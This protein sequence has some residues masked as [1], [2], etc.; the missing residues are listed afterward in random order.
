MRGTL[1]ICLLLGFIT[2]SLPAQEIDPQKVSR[3]IETA[4]K[5]LKKQQKPD[6]SW[7]DWHTFT[8]G[9]TSLVTLSLLE[10]GVPP[11]DEVIQKALNSLRQAPRESTYCVALQTMALC[12]AKYKTDIGLIQKNVDWLVDA[13]HDDGAWG[14]YGAGGRRGQ[15][16]SGTD[17]SNAQYA[18]LALYAAEEFS[19]NIEVSDRVWRMAKKYWAN[20]QNNDGSWGYKPKSRATG[21]MSC[22]GISSLYIA[23]TKVAEI[24]ALQEGQLCCQPPVESDALER[25]LRWMGQNFR[26]D[27]NPAGGGAWYYY[28]MYGLE[29]AGRLTASRFLVSQNGA[30][31]DWYREGVFELTHTNR[32]FL[33]GVFL[34]NGAESNK[35]ISTALALLFLAKGRRPLLMGKVKHGP[36]DDWNNHPQDAAHLAKHVGDEWGTPLSWQTIDVRAASVDELA[37][38][39]IL[40]ISGRDA[41][42]FNDQDALKLRLYI[43]QGGFIFAEA[44]CRN[45]AGMRLEFKNFI[46]KKIF[47]NEYRLSV[48]PPTH[49]I[50]RTEAVIPESFINKEV[51]SGVNFSC[52]TSLV[53]CEEDLSC[54]WQFNSPRQVR[55]LRESGNWGREFLEEMDLANKVGLNVC[56]YATNRELKYKYELFDDEGNGGRRENFSR[57]HLYIASLLHSGNADAASGALPNLQKALAKVTKLRIGFKDTL[58]S[59]ADDQVFQYPLLFMH[60]RNAFTFREQDRENLKLYCERGGVLLADSICASRQFDRSFRKE[61]QATFPNAKLEAIPS[62]HPI[63]T[64]DYGGYDISSVKRREPSNV[65]GEG[66]IQSVVRQVRPSLEGVKVGERYVVIYSPYD[67]SCALE[68]HATLECR[69]YLHEDALRI[70]VNMVLYAL[71]QP[72]P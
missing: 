23:S 28:Y 25:G 38:I 51:V 49:P 43:E 52:R 2:P 46:E 70:G 33:N 31:R 71:N 39:P 45:N 14:Y 72:G 18:L 59:P 8:S 22:A 32:Q 60:G 6:G 9:V 10:A 16:G 34:G 61:M 20:A 66:T 21:S 41:P 56:S 67:I 50:W 26:S 53:F 68:D 48:L 4:V 55:K 69:G 36:G 40:Y 19:P 44:C 63:Y 3:S 64:K 54:K 27:K 11:D 42:T 35:E 1:S 65:D 17:N 29:R 7:Q 62:D 5:W 12:A 57:G 30:K 13:Q 37:Q 24:E 58:L 15:R 47:N